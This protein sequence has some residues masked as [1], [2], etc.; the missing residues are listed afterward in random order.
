MASWEMMKNKAQD[1]QGYIVA[2]LTDEY[3]VDS[4]PCM[5][6]ST[7]EGKESKILE[8]RIF[9]KEQEIKLFRTDISKEF[10]MRCMDDR[11]QNRDYTEESQFLDIDTKK[12]KQTFEERNE[13]YATGG[14]KYYLPLKTMED[15]KVIIR[16]YYDSYKESGQARI[17]DWRLVDFQE[18]R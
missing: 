2:S 13:V 11:L 17:C 9:D 14:G 6:F 1:I 12:S 7:L 16:Y 10:K 15:A 5:Q 4:W 3:I 8:V 18:G